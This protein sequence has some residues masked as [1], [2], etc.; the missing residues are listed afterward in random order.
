MSCLEIAQAPNSIDTALLEKEIY[1]VLKQEYPL[2]AEVIIVDK[3]EIK[4]LNKT[5]RGIDKVTDVLSFPT[6]ENVCEKVINPKDFPL[7][8]IDGKVFLGSIAICI[9]R[10]EEQAIEYGHSTKREILYLLCHG[11]LHLFGYDHEKD[12]DK[13]KMRKIEELV[14]QNIGVKRC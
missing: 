11:L 8:V 5:L 7:D 4:R 3:E 6:L 10:A 9:E 2:S 13:V 14:M 1:K 12:A